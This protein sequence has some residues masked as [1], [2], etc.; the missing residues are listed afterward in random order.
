[1]TTLECVYDRAVDA[2]S[3]CK[4]RLLLQPEVQILVNEIWDELEALYPSGSEQW[5]IIDRS[6]R[7][8]TNWWSVPTMSQYVKG[9]DCG[10][11]EV[12]V[13]TIEE[14][15]GKP[16]RAQTAAHHQEY[17]KW[18]YHPRK[19]GKIYNTAKETRWLWLLGWRDKP[20]PPKKPGIAARLKVLWL[21]WRWLLELITAVVVLAAA[22]V[23]F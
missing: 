4:R 18:L 9:V 23:A 22:V 10:N 19:G 11:I 8:H 2:L 14:V 13:S 3:R 16:V 17:P 5:R 1:M 12:L 7:E 20:Y 15:F 21:E 6:K